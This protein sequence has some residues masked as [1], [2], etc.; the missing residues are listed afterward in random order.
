MRWLAAAVAI[1]VAVFGLSAQAADDLSSPAVPAPLD[2]TLLAMVTGGA[3]AALELGA[4]LGAGVQSID[5]T[6]SSSLQASI[7]RSSSHLAGG[8]KTGDIALGE[9]SVAM[10]GV[11]SAQLSAGIDNIQQSSTALAFV[12]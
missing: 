12:F 8:L 9:V 11:N 6:A 7:S 2:D 3:A 4:N 5:L 1:A 10:G